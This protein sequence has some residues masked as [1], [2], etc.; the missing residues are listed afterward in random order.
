MRALCRWR[1]TWLSCSRG[2]AGSRSKSQHRRRPPAP[3]DSIWNAAARG[4]PEAY[5]LDVTD[6]GITVRASDPR[7]LFYGA[8]TL[9]QLATADAADAG[10]AKIPQL[11]I[12]DGPRFAWRGFMLDSARHY[13]PPAFIRQLIDWMALHK[14]NVLHWHLTDDQGWRLEIRQYPE[15]TRNRRLA[16]TRGRGR[17]AALWRLLHAG[18]SARACRLCSLAFRNRRAGDRAAGSRPGGDRELPQARHRRNC[19]R[20]R[21]TGAFTTGSSTPT[22]R[23]SPSSRTS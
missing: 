9:W 16:Q 10:P 15:L 12:E 4:S 23:H 5:S 11:S 20:F 22:R 18:R 6:D 17:P 8:V 13:Q 1:V 19:R 2:R 14:L 3:F 7:G 21:P